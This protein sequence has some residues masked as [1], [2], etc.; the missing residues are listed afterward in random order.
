LAAEYVDVAVANSPE[1]D[2]ETESVLDTWREALLPDTVRVNVSVRCDAVGR[3][4]CVDVVLFFQREPVI[5][6]ETVALLDPLDDPCK[7][8]LAAV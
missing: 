3:S 8:K 6:I 4:V 2:V 7:L 5:S 1:S